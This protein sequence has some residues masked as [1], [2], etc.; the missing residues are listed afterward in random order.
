MKTT[1]F[2]ISFPL[3]PSVSQKN[4]TKPKS[5]AISRYTIDKEKNNINTTVL[6]EQ[7]P[8]VKSPEQWT[9]RLCAY[10][11][12]SARVRTQTTGVQTRQDPVCSI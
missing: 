3:S 8:S 5:K 4:P 9:G 7:H 1:A 6:R 10:A 12:L 11:Q 2:F